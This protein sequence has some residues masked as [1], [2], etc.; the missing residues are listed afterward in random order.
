MSTERVHACA[1][2][3]L[4]AVT[5]PATGGPSGPTP[6]Q[7]VA[8]LRNY[9]ATVPAPRARRGIRYPWMALLT[10]AAAAVLA[11]AASIAA[12]GEWVADAP[13]RVLALLGF[14]PDPLTG[15][16]RPPHATTIRL[17]PAAA[18]GDALDRA[19]SNFL[20]ERKS[21]APAPGRKVIAV[22]GKTLRGSRTA[23]R[24]ATALIAASTATR[25]RPSPCSWTST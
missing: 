24:T 3:F 6:L 15:L 4:H 22:D 19:T 17:V 16:I 18:D 8:D 5:P 10:A 13:Q 7:T 21:L 1:P 9:L 11:G 12:V 20:Q 14:R 23:R 2:I 25:S